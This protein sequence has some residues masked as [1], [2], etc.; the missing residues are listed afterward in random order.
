MISFLDSRN[1][2]KYKSRPHIAAVLNYWADD[3]FGRMIPTYNTHEDTTY[4]SKKSMPIDYAELIRSLLIELGFKRFSIK[5]EY[6]SGFSGPYKEFKEIF[7]YPESKLRITVSW[8][9]LYEHFNIYVS[10][11][12]EDYPSNEGVVPAASIGS[13]SLAFF[14]FFQKFTSQYGLST[15][16]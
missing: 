15:Q 16:I 9:G 10:L 2:L 13:S 3:G 1:S 6:V 8:N 4:P 12:G 14:Q 7:H 5:Q 11:S